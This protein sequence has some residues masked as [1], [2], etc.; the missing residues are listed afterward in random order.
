VKELN[1]YIVEE[2]L[3]KVT[4]ILRKH[5]VAGMAFAEIQGA[6]HMKR[7]EIRERSGWEVRTVTPK[8]EKRTKVDTIVADS[9][10]KGIVEDLIGSM[11]SKNEPRGMIFVKD[12]AN[13]HEIGTKLSGEALLSPA[14]AGQPRIE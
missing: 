4:D 10:V 1:I 6:G 8:Y 3:P 9:S 5:D 7:R 2:D 13:A 11:G 12:V 14:S